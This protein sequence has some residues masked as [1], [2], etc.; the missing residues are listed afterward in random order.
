MN[1]TFLFSLGAYIIDVGYCFFTGR[2]SGL[3]R[4]SIWLRFLSVACLLLLASLYFDVL[5]ISFSTAAARFAIR[6]LL[7]AGSLLFGYQIVWDKELYLAGFLTTTN[8]LV[9][10]VFLTPLTDALE[11]G[12]EVF[13][14]N[15]ALDYF[16]C[17][18]IVL[19]IRFVLVFLSYKT[20]DPTKISRADPA[21]AV[22]LALVALCAMYIRTIHFTLMDGGAEAAGRELSLYFIVLHAALL[23]VLLFHEKYQYNVQNSKALQAQE[24]MTSSLLRTLDLRRENDETVRRLRHDL[25]N[26]MLA[27]QSMLQDGKSG[28]AQEYIHTFIER[29]NPSELRIRTGRV[30]LD[31]LMS[32]KL[33]KAMDSGIAVSAVID[34]RA[35]DFISDF[36]LCM[37]MGNALDNAVE[38]CMRMPVDADRYIEV[39]G[40][41]SANTL[42]MRIRNSCI[43]PPQKIGERFITSKHDVREHGY[44]LQIIRRTVEQYGG[45][46]QALSDTPNQF[47]LL[48]TFPLPD[49]EKA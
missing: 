29:T 36:D 35:G 5:P 9:H 25:K 30:M 27:L 8:S 4:R 28:E 47:E 12:A 21:C 40:G 44:G 31:S 17:L 13:T 2:R 7:T 41:T 42:I 37:I 11:L 23:F 6:F 45:C 48:L 32:E 16:L 19:G 49:E 46:I 20:L 18:I 38:A 39:K 33:G 43:F 10:G 1:N 22:L 15:S 34:F 14:G 24:I 3:P 26:H